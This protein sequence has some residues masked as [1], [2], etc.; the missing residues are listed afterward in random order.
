MDRCSVYQ[1]SALEKS[2]EVQ[3]MH[4]IYKRAKEVIM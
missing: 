3:R 1:A 4:I 2:V